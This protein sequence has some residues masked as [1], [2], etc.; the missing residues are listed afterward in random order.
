M[1]N[2][3]TEMLKGRANNQV[4]TRLHEYGVAAVKFT[5]D[6]KLLISCGQS[7]PCCIIAID[8]PTLTIAHRMKVSF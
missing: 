3:N 7:D 4:F 1:G 8:I 2:R 5:K 6:E